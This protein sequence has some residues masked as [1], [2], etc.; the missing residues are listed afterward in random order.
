M[1]SIREIP[2]L[3]NIPVLVRAPLNM[4][5][6]DGK[7]ATAFRLERFA[8]TVKYLQQKH[9]R[10]ILCGHIGEKGTE[11]LE[12]VY[13][14]LKALVP[15]LT[16]CKT[17][18]G[19]E[20][21]A[22]VRELL[23]G[24]VLMLENLR[25]NPGEKANDEKFAAEL[26]SLADVFVEDC[27]DT[28]HREHASI[29]GVPTLLPSYAGF[30]VEEE[31][32]ELSKALAPKGPSLAVI[33]GAKFATK[34]PVLTKLIE[35]YDHVYVGGAL[36]NDFIKAK[37]NPVGASLTS[38]TGTE[39]I[40][41]LLKSPKL[42]IPED[43]VVAPRGK[44]RADGRVASLDDVQADEAILD[45]GP[46]TVEMLTGVIKGA[47]SILWNGPLGNYENGFVE[48]TEALAKVIAA[49]GGHSVV[50]GGDTVAA[51]EK[52]G[53]ND[54]FSFVSTGGGAMLDFLAKGTLPGI[55]A[56]G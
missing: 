42:L 22:A 26:A 28:C 24:H 35:T 19:P 36:A 5:I 40:R 46:K 7:V 44:T 1:R 31:V 32:A 25:Q 55:E 16:F 10:V 50:G 11:T 17:S 54:R 29:V 12:P 43:V 6:V 13:E 56:L 47:K 14:A 37:G 52:L 23:P 18:T 48:G 20:A 21:R 38:I 9:A 4:T 53:L 34:E 39:H 49:S 15:N 3:E 8:P 33:G 27:F 45:N 30:I 2:I 41:E 51:I